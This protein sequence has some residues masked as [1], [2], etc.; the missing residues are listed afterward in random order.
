MIVIGK[1]AMIEQSRWASCEGRACASSITSNAAPNF[2]T[3]SL[4]RLFD[5]PAFSCVRLHS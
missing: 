2:D 4:R 5:N 1:Y 3:R